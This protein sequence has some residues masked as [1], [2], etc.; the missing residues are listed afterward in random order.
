MCRDICY[1]IVCKYIDKSKDR[2]IDMPIHMHNVTFVT[3]YRP[4][5]R[6]VHSMCADR[7]MDMC[8]LR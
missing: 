6:H 5:Y 7:W 2:H 4:V 3:L 1:R 8:M